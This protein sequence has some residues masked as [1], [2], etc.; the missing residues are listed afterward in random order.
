MQADDGAVRHDGGG[1]DAGGLRRSEEGEP[2]LHDAV[3]GVHTCG[4]AV[5]VDKQ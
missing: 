1:H 4:E 3:Q 2:A 5:G